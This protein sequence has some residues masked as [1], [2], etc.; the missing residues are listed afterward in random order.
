MTLLAEGQPR[1]VAR[2][3]INNQLFHLQNS[4]S[5]RTYWKYGFELLLLF[6][7]AEYRQNIQSEGQADKRLMAQYGQ[8]RNSR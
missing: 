8:K 5:V 1:K 4:V 6:F 2:N 3:L 7:E